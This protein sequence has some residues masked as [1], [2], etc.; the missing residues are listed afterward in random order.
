MS[1]MFALTLLGWASGFSL[2]SPKGLRWISEK[3]GD[4]YELSELFGKM[5]IRGYDNWG[6]TN[7][8]L[9]SPLPRSQHAPIPSKDV[10]L[11]YVNCKYQ[12][13]IELD[14]VSVSLSQ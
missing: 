8:D 9:W 14:K 1:Y 10:A 11:Q 4:E 12:R 5:S 3:V 7:D 13:G 6:R 2:F